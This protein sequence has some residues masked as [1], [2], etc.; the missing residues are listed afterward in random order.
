MLGPAKG[1]TTPR[2]GGQCLAMMAASAGDAMEC[3]GGH[4]AATD[5]GLERRF[6]GPRRGGC[7]GGVGCVFVSMCFASPFLSDH[8][9]AE[10]F[11]FFSRVL[12]E[13]HCT[14]WEFRQGADLAGGRATYGGGPV[15]RSCEFAN[16]KTGAPR[17]NSRESVERRGGWNSSSSFIEGAGDLQDVGCHVSL[18]PEEHHLFM[19]CQVN[20]GHEDTGGNSG[21]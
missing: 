21:R 7:G 14:R 12:G 6:E 2:K 17:Q 16:R 9:P 11:P 8:N 4:G 20:I 1:G 13:A 19:A 18:S 5:C 10:S 15:R 3:R